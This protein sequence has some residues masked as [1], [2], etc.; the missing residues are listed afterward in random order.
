MLCMSDTVVCFDLDDT[1]YKEIDFVQSAYG[2]IAEKINHP[3]AVRQMMDWYRVGKNVFAELI[4]AYG[5]DLTVNDCIQIYRN[6]F[7]KILLDSGTKEFLEELKDYGALLGLITDGRSFSQRNKIKAL[8]LEGIFDIEVISG[9]LGSEKPDHRNYKVVMDRFP[10]HRNFLYVGDN[11]QKDFL[12]PNQLGWKT[13][14]LLDDGRNIHKQDFTLDV[15]Y[16]PSYIIKSI[17]DLLNNL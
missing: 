6:H 10:T 11:P 13:F 17:S 8:G 3:E 14:C 7:P 12:A 1:L 15:K 4:S 5:S 9:E 2:E 16:L